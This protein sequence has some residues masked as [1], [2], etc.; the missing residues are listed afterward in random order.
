[1]ALRSSSAEARK[2]LTCASVWYDAAGSE[3]RATYYRLRYPPGRNFFT[4]L[5]TTRAAGGGGTLV[6]RM[7]MRIEPIFSFLFTRWSPRLTEDSFTTDITGIRNGPVRSIVRARQALDLGRLLPDAP[8]KT[9][10]YMKLPLNLAEHRASRQVFPLVASEERPII[11]ASSLRFPVGDLD[12]Q[13]SPSYPRC[14]NGD[15][16][17]TVLAVT[18]RGDERT[19][20]FVAGAGWPLAPALLDYLVGQRPD[21]VYISGPDL[22]D[23]WQCRS[24]GRRNPGREPDG[25]PVPR[26]GGVR[27]R[28]WE[29]VRYAQ[30]LYASAV[31]EKNIE[32]LRV[33]RS[34]WPARVSR[35][36]AKTS[37]C[38]GTRSRSGAIAT[39]SS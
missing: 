15:H 28:G 5:E 32:V 26:Q 16:E 9:P 3:V 29:M 34:A 4:T 19:F 6:A 27:E 1:M 35:S 12:V 30:P 38:R 20:V 8:A 2:A 37:G 31:A 39:S 25:G 21:L 33:A 11:L 13:C 10:V 7:T 22:A 24:A 36:T 18:L 14:R 23:D 17:E